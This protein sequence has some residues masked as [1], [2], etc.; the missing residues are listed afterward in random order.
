LT[1]TEVVFSYAVFCGLGYA[2]GG[3]IG[4]WCGAGVV[5][6]RYGYLVWRSAR[7]AGADG[8]DRPD[9]GAETPADVEGEPKR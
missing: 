3:A 8:K 2:A 9:A 5:T 6:I 4:L 1:L 7:A